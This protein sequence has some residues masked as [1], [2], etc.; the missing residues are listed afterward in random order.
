MEVTEEAQL[1]IAER[2]RD[3]LCQLNFWQLLQNCTKNRIWKGSH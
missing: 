1:Y 2:P 3:V